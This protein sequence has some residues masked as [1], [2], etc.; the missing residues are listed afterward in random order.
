MANFQ[1]RRLELLKQ[2]SDRLNQSSVCVCHIQQFRFDA[3]G[4]TWIIFE[5]PVSA[6]LRLNAMNCTF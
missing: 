4:V 1:L 5:R 3:L 2:F 6:D